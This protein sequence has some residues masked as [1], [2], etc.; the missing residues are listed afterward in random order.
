M[1]KVTHK[2]KFMSIFRQK[3]EGMTLRR[4]I[5]VDFSTERAGY[6]IDASFFG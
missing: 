6:R 4:P 5:L 1:K 2:L 3:Q